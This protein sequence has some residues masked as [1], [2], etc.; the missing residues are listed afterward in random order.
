[1]IS[2]WFRLNTDRYGWPN[3]YT[4][5]GTPGRIKETLNSSGGLLT[6]VS[7]T[8]NYKFI[9]W[10]THSSYL[11]KFQLSKF[12]SQLHMTKQCVTLQWL[13]IN[14]YAWSCRPSASRSLRHCTPLGYVLLFCDNIENGK[15]FLLLTCTKSAC[16]LNSKRN[17]KILM[18]SELSKCVPESAQIPGPGKLNTDMMLRKMASMVKFLL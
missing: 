14:K 6:N 3:L 16:R 1:M 18:T 9:I 10:N 8:A 15:H 7:L 13:Q 5:F 2:D 17:F 11:K 12:I 4:F